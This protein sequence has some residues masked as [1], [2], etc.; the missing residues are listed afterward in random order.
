MGLPK[1]VVLELELELRVDGRH[2]QR[3]PK[4]D[5]PHGHRVGLDDLGAQLLSPEAHLHV[6]VDRGA[7]V[8]Q[9]VERGRVHLGQSV[10]GV[11]GHAHKEQL[12]LHRGRH[13]R[14]A[15]ALLVLRFLI[16]VGRSVA[17]PREREGELEVAGL[18]ARGRLTHQLLA[19]LVR[20]REHQPL[21]VELVVLAVV[22]R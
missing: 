5:V 18:A 4:L 14:H 1:V 7:L 17:R 16:V 3:H 20:R 22:E 10:C 2:E 19:R 21:P 9:L 15:L 6:R 12:L 13:E 11:D 8:V